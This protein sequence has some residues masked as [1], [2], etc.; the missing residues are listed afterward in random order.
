MP[1]SP[2]GFRVP[3]GQAPAV[4]PFESVETRRFF[5]SDGPP[6]NPSQEF[7]K[8]GTGDRWQTCCGARFVSVQ[9]PGVTRPKR[10]VIL[11]FDW[12]FKV[13]L[14]LAGAVTCER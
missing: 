2:L 13:K 7:T 3:S 12:N 8:S 9:F 11:R 1:F 14:Q 10:S 5:S 6:A 4:G